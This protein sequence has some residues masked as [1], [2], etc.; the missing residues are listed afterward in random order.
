[1]IARSETDGHIISICRMIDACGLADQ[2]TVG[3]LVYGV[4]RLYNSKKYATHFKFLNFSRIITRGCPG[5]EMVRTI[6]K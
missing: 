6:L 1:M 5:K 2:I 4:R 3:K